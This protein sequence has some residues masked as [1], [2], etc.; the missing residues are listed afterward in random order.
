MP[1]YSRDIGAD[2]AW[3]A[4]ATRRMNRMYRW[5]RYIYDATRRYYLL[6]R[7]RL[8]AGLRMGRRIG[9]EK[10]ESQS[11]SRPHRR[12]LRRPER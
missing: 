5:Q 3:P 6:G 12:F 9:G 10:G 7:D 4:E 11:E 8:I 1:A 2:A